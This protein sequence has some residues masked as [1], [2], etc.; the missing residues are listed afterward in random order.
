[1]IPFFPNLFFTSLI[2]LI[3]ILIVFRAKGKSAPRLFIFSIMWV[4]LLLVIGLTIFPI[5]YNGDFL[6]LKPIDQL[7]WVLS[8]INWIPFHN[9]NWYNSKILL[10]EYINNILLTI[11]FGI[12]INFFAK[13]NW[14]NIFWVSLG[15]GLAIETSQFIMSLFFGPYRTVDINDV[16][17]NATGTF[18]GYLL[19]AFTKDFI[20]R[21]RE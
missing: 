21:L 3:P 2:V 12:L 13:L 6:T 7:G 10:I 19:Y 20:F 14:K 5:P 11:P 9:L 15:S 4:Y 8:R 18:A 17:F 1:M 16:I